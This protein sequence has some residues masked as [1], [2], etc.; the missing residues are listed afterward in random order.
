MSTTPPKQPSQGAASPSEPITTTR[1][2]ILEAGAAIVHAKGFNNT[3]LKEV[4]D[5]SGVPKGSF[6]FYFKNKEAFGL[7]LIDHHL[8]FF[9]ANPGALLMDRDKPPL[10][11]LGNFI[12]WF[13]EFYRDKGFCLGCPVGNL[14]QEM[15]DLSPP[16]RE[17]LGKAMEGLNR[18]MAQV[19][20]EAKE[21]GHLGPDLDPESTARFIIWAWQGALMFMK[22]VNTEEPLITLK[23]TIFSRL[24]AHK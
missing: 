1:E 8:A 14:I 18:G 2:R 7:E 13:R 9:A 6:Y 11:R 16:F 17:K 24:L 3:G 23:Q 22:L 15:S 10:E 5:A 21:R 4:L 20:A 19:L 12:D